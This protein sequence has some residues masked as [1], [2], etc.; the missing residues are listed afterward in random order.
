[1]EKENIQLVIDEEPED[2]DNKEK[3]DEIELVEQ[4]EPPQQ[5]VKPPEKITIR[6]K[7]PKKPI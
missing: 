4:Q 3:L 5:S 6:V 7:K 1:L 2:K